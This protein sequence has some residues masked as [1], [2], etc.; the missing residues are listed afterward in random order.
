M[1]ND[2]RV[3]F[4]PWTASPELGGDLVNTV[5]EAQ[6]GFARAVAEAAV[7]AQFSFARAVSLAALDA[8]HAVVSQLTAGFFTQ[9]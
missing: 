3:T 4:S 5:L 9:R 2:Y 1:R 8:Q 6:L 7:T